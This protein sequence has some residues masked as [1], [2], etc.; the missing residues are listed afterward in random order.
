ML[1]R[2]LIVTYFNYP[3][4]TTVALEVCAMSDGE[5]DAVAFCGRRI[6]ICQRFG[7]G[8]SGYFTTRLTRGT[9]SLCEHSDRITRSA[10]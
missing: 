4:A 2:L 7:R 10:L 1:S 9:A 8:V 5:R 6:D 3:G